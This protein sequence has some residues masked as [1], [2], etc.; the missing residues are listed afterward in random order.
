MQYIRRTILARQGI[1]SVLMVLGLAIINAVWVIPTLQSTRATASVFALTVAERIQSE[2]N[3]S[4]ANALDNTIEVSAKLAAEPQRTVVTFRNLLQYH[5]I[6]TSVALVDRSGKELVRIDSSGLLPPERFIDQS[7][8]SSLYLALQG[9][10][11]FSLPIISPNGEFHMTLAVPVPKEGEFIDKIIIAELNIQ[12]LLSIIRSPKIGQGHVYVLDRDGVQILHPD[13]A[14]IGEHRNFGSRPIAK[15]VL[16]NGSTANGLAPDDRYV[17][18]DGEDTFTVGMPTLVVKW[19][20]FVEQPRGQAFAGQ[21]QTITLAIVTFLLAITIFLVIVRTTVKL[22]TLSRQLEEAN[23][24]LKEL[25]QQKSEFVSIA[26]HQLRTPLTIIKGYVS[27]VQEGE[28]GAP[29]KNKKLQNALAIV[30]NSTDQLVK[31]VS[32]LLDLSRIES[33][34][35][36]YESKESDFVKMAERII[37]EYAP[38]AEKKKL[39]LVLKNDAKALAPFLFDT[40]KMREVVVNIIDNA[41][42]YSHT[43]EIIVSIGLVNKNENQMLRFSVKDQGLGIKKEDIPQLF[44]KFSRLPEARNRVATGTGIGLYF[45]KRIVEDHGGRIGVESLG[46]GKGSTF[47]IELPIRR[48]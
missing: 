34:K 9:T 36:H 22:R 16:V 8:N 46:L 38:A 1:F 40:D 45:A 4:L 12:N 5:P 33:G 10:S 31:L 32:D 24:H 26:G 28:F 35:I 42:K 29:R 2:I 3:G 21:R 37:Q 25:D 18:E 41:M 39:K 23:E 44:V 17:N 11:K 6:F 30:A 14:K 19:G 20:V 7:R 47:W 43:G 27:L 13:L 48:R 15:K